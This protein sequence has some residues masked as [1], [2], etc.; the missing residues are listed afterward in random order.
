M[1]QYCFLSRADRICGNGNWGHKR[2]D[3][4]Y[5]K[6]SECKWTRAVHTCAVQQ[7]TVK[8]ASF[9]NLGRFKFPQCFGRCSYKYEAL[10]CGN[11]CLLWYLFRNSKYVWGKAIYLKTHLTTDCIGIPCEWEWASSDCRLPAVR[12]VHLMCAYIFMYFFCSLLGVLCDNGSGKLENFVN[13]SDALWICE[14][15]VWEPNE[16]KTV[17]V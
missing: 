3:H 13:N 7:A 8:T 4:S 12:W 15:N 14:G 2:V 17:C 1:W 16:K 6:R 9:C 5:W 11:R 10:G